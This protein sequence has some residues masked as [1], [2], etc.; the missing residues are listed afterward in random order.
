MGNDRTAVI[1]PRIKNIKQKF[2]SLMVIIYFHLSKDK[3]KYTTKK[4]E[5][6]INLKYHLIN[7]NKTK[8]KN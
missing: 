6:K 3:F 8:K 7:E 4:T 2:S 1:K 5:K